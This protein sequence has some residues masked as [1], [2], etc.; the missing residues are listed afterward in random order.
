MSFSYH[1][2]ISAIRH[3]RPMLSVSTWEA[4]IKGRSMRCCWL[5]KGMT[6][7]A[8][9]LKY[10]VHGPSSGERWLGECMWPWAL[11]VSSL[12]SHSGLNRTRRQQASMW[13]AAG[14]SVPSHTQPLECPAAP[15]TSGCN[16]MAYPACKVWC[17]HWLVWMEHRYLGKELRE[18]LSVD[19]GT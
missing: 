9:W 16:S 6:G 13:Q 12:P 3:P 5:V 10:R 15:C 17:K 4:L 18:V 11:T 8:L 7:H 2:H 1:C 14:R 19:P